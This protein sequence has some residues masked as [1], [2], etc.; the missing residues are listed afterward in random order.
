MTIIAIICSILVIALSG[1]YV[2]YE[3]SSIYI[4]FVLFFSSILEIIS[5]L[6]ILLIFTTEI[7]VKEKR[8]LKNTVRIAQTLRRQ[9]IGLIFT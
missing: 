8:R 6:V 5:C 4:I 3:L 2:S 7:K 1:I 9:K